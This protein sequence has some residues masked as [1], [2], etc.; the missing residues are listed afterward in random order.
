MLNT[1]VF[2]SMLYSKL[3][4]HFLQIQEFVGATNSVVSDCTECEKMEPILLDPL[5]SFVN[6]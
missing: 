3:V 6:L 2:S 1:G 5:Q 4:G